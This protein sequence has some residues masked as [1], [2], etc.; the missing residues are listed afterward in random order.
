M[1]KIIC[2][3]MVCASFLFAQTRDEI[4]QKA[5]EFEANGDYKNAMLYYKK[6][7]LPDAS[8]GYDKALAS[9]GGV[10]SKTTNLETQEI[11]QANYQ[12]YQTTA[13]YATTSKQSE[14]SLYPTAGGDEWAYIYKPNYFGYA[15]DTHDTADRKQG[16]IKFQISAQKPLFDN[17]LG[18][19]ETWT[20]AY[21]QTSF[22][23]AHM[24][25]WPF[26]TTN[27]EPEFFVTIP[28]N[29]WG[30]DYWRVGLS[31]ESNGKGGV[32]SRSWNKAYLQTSFALGNLR[33][34]PTVWHSF[35]LDDYNKDIRQYMGYGDIKFD[36]DINKHRISALLRNNLRFDSENRGALEL[37]WYFPLF[38]DT[39]GF[40]QYFTGYGE[41][42]EDYNRHVDKGMIGIAIINK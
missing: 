35:G 34:T 9:S 7:A 26:R 23:Q 25:S 41:S 1:K 36:Y 27:Y 40:V 18:L 8:M 37:N 21:T 32:E 30:L 2:L 33:I 5:M 31:H 38:K 22:W 14:K 28:A 19:D 17:L 24:E 10:D 20:F 13:S 6:L 29:Y 4:L 11:A 12:N 16:E 42:L 39:Y 3:S 15:Y